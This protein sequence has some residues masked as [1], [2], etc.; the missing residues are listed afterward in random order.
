MLEFYTKIF[1]LRHLK[2]S[3]MYYNVKPLIVFLLNHYNIQICKFAKISIKM[4]IKLRHFNSL[5]LI[6]I[7]PLKLD[8]F[9]IVIFIIYK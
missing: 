2:I 8:T 3:N 4:R 6:I 5:M 9:I 7:L 1:F